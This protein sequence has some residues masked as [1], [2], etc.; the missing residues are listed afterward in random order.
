MDK[1][2]L[3]LLNAADD[4]Q[5]SEAPKGFDYVKEIEAVERIKP[6]LERIVGRLFVL[7][8]NVQDA[9]FFTEL[10]IRQSELEYMAGIGNVIL[11]VLAIRFSAFG[12]L[13]TVWS[14]STKEKVNRNLIDEVVATLQDHG[15]VYVDADALQE[16][17]TGSHTDFKDTTWW[18]RFFDYI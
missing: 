16:S 10:S 13:F 15:Y 14:N 8:E 7:D 9:S 12:K 1:A 18:L 17:Y 5:E 2:T 4:P 6:E 11:T 3:N